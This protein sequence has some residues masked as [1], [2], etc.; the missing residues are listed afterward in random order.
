[1][2]KKKFWKC[3]HFDYINLNKGNYKMIQKV[4][5]LIIGLMTM[6]SYANEL[7]YMMKSDTY[8]W[9]LDDSGKKLK[10]GKFKAGTKFKIV[11]VDNEH[12]VA[13]SA[14]TTNVKYIAPKTF[15]ATAAPKRMAKLLCRCK[16]DDYYNYEWSD[17]E[18]THWSIE[19]YAYTDD[20]SDSELF[21]GFVEKKSAL[22]KKIFSVL[23]DGKEHWANMV[24]QYQLAEGTSAVKIIDFVKVD[25]KSDD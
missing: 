21:S 24:L 25:K 13:N 19:L 5:M 23:E 11:V 22:G 20:Q 17:C 9:M 12:V 7:V 2:K 4:V 1:M 14:K 10:S 8:A 18:K 16:L 15:K 6:F 3:V